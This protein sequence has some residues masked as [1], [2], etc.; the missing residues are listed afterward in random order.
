[1]FAEA[2]KLEHTVFALPFA[3]LGLVLGSLASR[4]TAWPGW[5]VFLLVLAAMVSARTAAMA[6]NRIADRELDALNPRTAGRAIPAGKISLKRFK[7]YF[8]LAVAGFFAASAALGS[9]PLALSPVALAVILGYSHAKRATWLCHWILGLGLGIAPAAAYIAVAS[10]WDA[11]ILWPVVAVVF[12]TAGF[13]ILYSLQDE[14]FD[15][16]ARLHSAP[17]RFGG[18]G[19]LALSR[20][21]HVVA[22][23]C[24]AATAAAFR[25]TEWG[26]SAVVVVA[27]LL[28]FEQSLVRH[29][30]LRR[31]NAAF[32]TVNGIVSV[33]YFLLF[34]ADFG[35]RTRL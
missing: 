28:A 34:L 12:W 30:D 20:A 3:M 22:A 6:Y 14:D 26:W 16:S 21:S 35:P 1:V 10:G 17:A 19:A 4:G 24:L 18:R 33:V 5:P 13:D 31:V 32:F 7:L 2:V 23:G 9:L 8:T 15:K 27:V 11:R 25:A 29:D